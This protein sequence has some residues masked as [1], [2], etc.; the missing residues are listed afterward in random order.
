MSLSYLFCF[1]HVSKAFGVE[2]GH[3]HFTPYY[4]GAG[5]IRYLYYHYVRNYCRLAKNIL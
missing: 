2:F 4:F 5:V 3:Q 1:F